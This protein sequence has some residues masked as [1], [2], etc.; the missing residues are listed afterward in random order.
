MTMRWPAWLSSLPEAQKVMDAFVY[1]V[2]NDRALPGTGERPEEVNPMRVRNAYAAGDISAFPGWESGAKLP[3]WYDNE[4]GEWYEDRYQVGS[5]VGNTSYAA[6]ALMQYYKAYGGEQYLQTAR[7]LMD[8]VSRTVLTEA[9][10]SSAALTAGR[11][12]ILRLSIHSPTNPLNTTSTL[13]RYS[14]HSTKSPASQNTE[15]PP[16][17]LFDS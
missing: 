1:A 11:R 7:S 8:W 4:T 15:K 5:N 6:M 10:A 3:G 2:Q 13:M 14:A 12:E 16:T 17:V 9:T